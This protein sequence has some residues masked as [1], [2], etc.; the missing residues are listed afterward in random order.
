MTKVPDS[1]KKIRSNE[2]A[3]PKMGVN[4][5]K[6]TLN[7][8]IKLGLSRRNLIKERLTK[9]KPIMNPKSVA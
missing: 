6:G 9:I 5:Y 3:I 4:G 7:G 1:K 2:V 8:L